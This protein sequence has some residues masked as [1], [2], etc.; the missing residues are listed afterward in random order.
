MVSEIKVPCQCGMENQDVMILS[1]AGKILANCSC[2]YSPCNPVLRLCQTAS[3][4]GSP[5]VGRKTPGEDSAFRGR[6]SSGPVLAML[7]IFY[8][9][10]SL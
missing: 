5:G 6:I 3:V 4:S 8:P 10:K 7:G 9:R 2:F 1:I